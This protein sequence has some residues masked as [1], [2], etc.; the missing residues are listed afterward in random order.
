MGVSLNNSLEVFSVTLFYISRRP[1]HKY[2]RISN[3]PL[4]AREDSFRF[5]KSRGMK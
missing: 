3:L 2:L 5:Y 1:D 4:R